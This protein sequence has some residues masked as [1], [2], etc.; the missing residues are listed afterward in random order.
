MSPKDSAAFAKYHEYKKWFV[1]HL[2]LFKERLCA[3]ISQATD[4]VKVQSA[5]LRTLVEL[6]KRE[7]MY[8]NSGNG[9]YNRKVFGTS[10]YEKLLDAVLTAP[11]MDVDLLLLVRSE[12]LSHSLRDQ[13]LFVHNN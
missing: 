4:D 1:G 13:I 8:T 2:D 12:V 11:Q 10:T 3:I 5:A 7:Y 6:V 9:P